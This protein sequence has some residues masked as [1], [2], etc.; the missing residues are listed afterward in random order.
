MAV[1]GARAACRPDRAR[2]LFRRQ[3]QRTAGAT[4]YQAFIDELQI[5]GFKDGQNLIVDFRRVEQ[6]LRALSADAAA[7]VRSNV[8][9]LVTQGTEPALQAALG[10]T[11]TLPIVMM[12]ANYDPFA[13]M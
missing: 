8:N 9:V 6:D 11:R 13:S 7:L 4:L 12:A 1:R 2:R 10:A 5:H 3:S